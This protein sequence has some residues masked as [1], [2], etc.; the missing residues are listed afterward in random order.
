MARP[1]RSR[2]RRPTY[3]AASRVVRLF[4]ILLRTPNGRDLGGI[5]DEMSVSLK[6]AKRYADVLVNAVHGQDGLPL[7]EVVKAGGRTRLRVRS[8]E[9]GLDSSEFQAASIFFA[10]TALRSLRGTVVGDGADEVWDRFKKGLPKRTRDAL[11]SIER[12]FFYVPFA[13]KNYERLDE[14]LGILMRAVLRQ[15]ELR[16]RYRRADKQANSHVF[17][18]WTFV[19]YRDG[20]YLLGK[21]SRHAKPIWI[22]VDRIESVERT[23][24]RFSPPTDFDPARHT[25]GVFG[26]WAGPPTKVVLRLAG[27]A[28]EQIPERLIHPSQVFTELRGGGL[29]MTFQVRGW[30]ELAW[31]ILSWG[32]DVEVLEPAELRD[33]VRRNVREAAALY[34][35]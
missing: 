12:K 11:Q 24:T 32:G 20:L 18:P 29:L 5:A 15:E 31:W 9:A 8:E 14:S 21:S 23:G 3:G 35:R 25:E 28:A 34:A 19:L 26:I 22:A 30:Q 17:E 4:S 6:T 2:S 33:Y 27:R 16:F 13:A 1:A 7:V 10:A